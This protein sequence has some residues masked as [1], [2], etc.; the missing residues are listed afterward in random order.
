MFTLYSFAISI[1]LAARDGQTVYNLLLYL[2]GL[3][4]SASY[5]ESPLKL[6]GCL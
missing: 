1:K 6:F 5:L 4:S 2:C 3:F